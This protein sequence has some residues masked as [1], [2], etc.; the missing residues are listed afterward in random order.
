MAAAEAKASRH[1]VTPQLHPQGKMSL[2]V[3]SPVPPHG[4][5][6]TFFNWNVSPVWRAGRRHRQNRFIRLVNCATDWR[7][8]PKGYCVNALIVYSMLLVIAVIK[9][10]KNDKENMRLELLRTSWTAYF[11]SNLRRRTFT[12]LT[13]LTPL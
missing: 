4:R 5:D 6:E 8:S 2:P 13:G 7:S 9:R 1:A 12:L 11:C 10:K 3:V